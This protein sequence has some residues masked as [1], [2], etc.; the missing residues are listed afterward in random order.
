MNY[1]FGGIGEAHPKFCGEQYSDIYSS[2]VF[3]CYSSAQRSPIQGSA[4]AKIKERR[5]ALKSR[6]A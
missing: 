1:L 3:P 6:Q 5:A 4:L 2:Q